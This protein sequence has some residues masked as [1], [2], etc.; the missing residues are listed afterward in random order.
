MDWITPS[1]LYLCSWKLLPLALG[2]FPLSLPCHRISL[3]QG[4]IKYMTIATFMS[5]MLYWDEDQSSFPMN[6]ERCPFPNSYPESE[7]KQKLTPSISWISKCS[8]WR[9]KRM[10]NFLCIQWEKGCMNFSQT[11]LG[12]YYVKDAVHKHNIIW[13]KINIRPPLTSHS[14]NRPLLW[15]NAR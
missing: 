15:M 10:E 7:F 4:W 3:L 9:P 2:D 8:D 11:L 14:I 13:Y 6:T 5:A 1:F 12:D